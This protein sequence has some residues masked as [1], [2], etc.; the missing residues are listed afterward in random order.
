MTTEST[1][2]DPAQG[3]EETK[4]GTKVG[5]NG[6]FEGNG[7]PTT[8]PPDGDGQHEGN[9]PAPVAPTEK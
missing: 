1:K 8:T 4:G 9:E 5:T 6:Q 3:P 7:I 2:V